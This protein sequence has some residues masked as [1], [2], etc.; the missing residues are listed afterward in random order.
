MSKVFNIT[1][2]SAIN[3]AKWR[4]QERAARADFLTKIALESALKNGKI[5]EIF[6]ELYQLGFGISAREDNPTHQQWLRE[7]RIIKE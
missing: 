7:N 1:R 5:D 3:L 4:V 2:Q 6:D